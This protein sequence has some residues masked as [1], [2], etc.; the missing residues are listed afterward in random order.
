[1][2]DPKLET[3]KEVLLEGTR[4]EFVQTVLRHEII[5]FKKLYQNILKISETNARYHLT[6]LSEK[7]II[8]REKRKGTKAIFLSVNSLYLE[9]LR[10][11]YQIQS[12]YAYLGMVGERN[13]GK[14]IQKAI[15]SLRK[16]GW[17]FKFINIF[18]TEQNSLVL[19]KSS[20]WSKL[21]DSGNQTTL[22]IVPLYDFNTT[23]N[24]MKSTLNE[25]I[26]EYSI[27]IDVT[28]GTKIHS[29]S[30]YILAQEYGL[31]RVYIPENE[32]SIIISLP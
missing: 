30:L 18:T 23:Y 11:Y 4:D 19:Q 2:K 31:K 6:I 8:Q 5:E 16:S 14:Q 28:G 3:L 20:E 15:D 24:I 21:T 27:M 9:Q 17:Y 25:H 32:E 29:L 1:M 22:S 26:R 10:Q 7:N 13:P 12:Q